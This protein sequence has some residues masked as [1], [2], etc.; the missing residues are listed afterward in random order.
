MIKSSLLHVIQRKII[1]KM[2]LKWDEMALTLDMRCRFQ[3]RWRNKFKFLKER[4]M[5]AE[6]YCNLLQGTQTLFWSIFVFSIFFYLQCL[7]NAFLI[8]KQNL[9]CH[10]KSYKQDRQLTILCYLNKACARFIFTILQYT[11]RSSSLS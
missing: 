7:S 8:I 10:S 2:L 3:F 11:G 6:L 4:L 5:G 9:E 1:W